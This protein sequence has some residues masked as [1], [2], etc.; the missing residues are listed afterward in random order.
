MGTPRIN[1]T[2]APIAKSPVVQFDPQ[3][4]YVT[5]QEYESGGDNLLSTA[6]SLAAQRI[7]YEFTR[8]AAVSRIVASISGG[9]PGQNDVELD[10][11]QILANEIEKDV[12]QH[13]TFLAMEES[14][15]GTIG[16]VVRDVELYNEGKA[17][18]SPAPNAGATANAAKLFHLLVRGS[19]HY[20]DTQY[21]LRH[22]TN[23]GGG[24]SANIAD[25][26]VNKIYTTTQLITECSSASSWLYPLPGRL[27][28]KLNQIPDATDRTNYLW[29]WRKLASTET[30]AANGRIEINTD[31]SL[32]QWSTVLYTEVT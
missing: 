9:Q 22:T 4:G 26:N 28:Y 11:W 32:D 2:L 25:T 19:V 30:T 29:G 21:V 6:Q 5:R 14:Y 12:K 31:Y 15:A 10:T 24:Y 7:G 18:G 13:P 20:A 27:V 16:Y 1:G 8:S 23:V 3:R 17:P